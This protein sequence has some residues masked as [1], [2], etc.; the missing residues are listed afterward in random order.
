L[1]GKLKELNVTGMQ[2]IECSVYPYLYHN[3]GV[4]TGN[5]YEGKL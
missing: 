2:N 4:L 1:P 3:I 5:K